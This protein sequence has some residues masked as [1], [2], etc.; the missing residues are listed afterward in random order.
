MVEVT[1]NVE[2]VNIHEPDVFVR[3]DV[4]LKEVLPINAV[5]TEFQVIAVVYLDNNVERFNC[6]E[7]LHTISTFYR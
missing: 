2:D 7:L 4:N 1:I 6:F 3:S 5:V